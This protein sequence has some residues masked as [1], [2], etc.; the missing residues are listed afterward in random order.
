MRHPAD[1][2]GALTELLVAE[3]E[4]CPPFTVRLDFEGSEAQ[5]DGP[6]PRDG[7]RTDRGTVVIARSVALFVVA[8]VF[9]IGGSW[10]VRQGPREH[11]SR[12]WTG[13][14]G[15]LALGVYG[16]VATL[17]ATPVR[18]DARRP[19]RDVRRRLAALGIV[20]DG[21]QPDRYDVIGA[22]VCV[23]GVAGIMFAP[24]SGAV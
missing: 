21:Y 10:L 12:I 16:F 24:R 13:S 17:S 9:E 11:R 2:V 18:T 7:R 3:Q 15:I 23:V 5:F 8:A 1:V 20:A 14:A 22:R 4:C 19:S 6:Y